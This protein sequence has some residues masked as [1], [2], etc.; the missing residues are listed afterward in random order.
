MLGRDTAPLCPLLELSAK[1]SLPWRTQEWE[2]LE[3]EPSDHGAESL[4]HG[5]S[6]FP[7]RQ[8]VE[9]LPGAA[10]GLRDTGDSQV[11]PGVP[12][13]GRLNVREDAEGGQ[14]DRSGHQSSG[15]CVGGGW[16]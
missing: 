11:T 7:P 8:R 9:R 3:K 5:V 6:V 2:T 14:M 10:L 4:D 1:T 15:E 13:G 12:G 16:E